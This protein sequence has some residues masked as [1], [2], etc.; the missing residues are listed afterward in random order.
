VALRVALPFSRSAVPKGRR[1][2][3]LWQRSRQQSQRL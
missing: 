2:G 1:R 3:W